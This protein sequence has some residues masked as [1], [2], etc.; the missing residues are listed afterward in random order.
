MTIAQLTNEALALPLSD[1]ILLAERLWESVNSA[2]A[3]ERDAEED[4]LL[5]EATR[6]LD[7]MKRGAVKTWSHDQVMENITK[8]IQCG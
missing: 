8:A 1:R 6:R 3:T 2:P 4:A 7:E 5:Q